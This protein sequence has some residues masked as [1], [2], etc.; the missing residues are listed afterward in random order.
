MTMTL[1]SLA[2]TRRHVAPLALSFIICALAVF[3][4]L[5]SSL[6]MYA[7][8]ASPYETGFRHG[9]EDAAIEDPSERYINQPGKGPSEHTNSFN[10]SYDFGFDACS[11]TDQTLNPK[12]DCSAKA[13]GCWG[14]IYCDLLKDAGSCYDRYEGN[15][16]GTSTNPVDYD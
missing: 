11:G 9:C 15:D 14:S 3:P 6:M 1:Y 8:A 10:V 5:S 2:N 7:Q 16:D 12:Y 13:D 4:P